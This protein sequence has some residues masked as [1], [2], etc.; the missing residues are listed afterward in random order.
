MALSNLVTNHRSLQDIKIRYFNTTDETHTNWWLSPSIPKMFLLKLS[1]ILTSLCSLASAIIP[2]PPRP[3][4]P[5]VP[6]RAS[7][8]TSGNNGN[9]T[10][11][12]ITTIY[13]FNQ[14]IDHNNPGLGTFQ[15]RYWHTWN[16]YQPGK[17]YIPSS[18]LALT[19]SQEALSFS[20]HLGK[21]TPKVGHMTFSL[22]HKQLTLHSLSQA[23]SAI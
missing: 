5:P 12:P 6:P 8:L 7:A 9:T 16:F 10:I 20:S 22:T 23:I 17:F 3:T 1:V 18:N 19:V 21:S 13:Y 14:L 15:Q 11:P 4:P 2:S